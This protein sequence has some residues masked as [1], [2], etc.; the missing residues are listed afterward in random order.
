[1]KSKFAILA[2]GALILA[3]A[4]VSAAVLPVMT[5]PRGPVTSATTWADL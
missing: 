5:A 3:T 4:T 1:M 2:I